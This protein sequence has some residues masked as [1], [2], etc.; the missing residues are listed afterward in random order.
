MIRTRVDVDGYVDNRVVSD[1][2]GD[3]YLDETCGWVGAG[4]LGLLAPAV[5]SDWTGA[6]C[7]IG[8]SDAVGSDGGVLG[9]VGFRVVVLVSTV[10]SEVRL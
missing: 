3:G 2:G 1:V 8:L 6:G 5:G 4:G 7:G 9:V 10:G